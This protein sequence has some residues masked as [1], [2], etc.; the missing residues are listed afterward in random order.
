MP[1]D[2]SPAAG[3]NRRELARPVTWP[4][5]SGRRFPLA[6]KA[7]LLAPEKNSHHRPYISSRHLGPPRVNPWAAPVLPGAAPGL[8]TRCQPW[9][10]QVPG[11][12]QAAPPPVLGPSPPWSARSFVSQALLSRAPGDPITC[13]ATFP[14]HLLCA[15]AV[16]A[17]GAA[18]VNEPDLAPA[19]VHRA[20]T[21][22][23]GNKTGVN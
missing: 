16:Q 8:P 10:P 15:G 12:S 18:L 9:S 17:P 2:R 5:W 7:W 22:A 19:L 20:S 14:E 1:L 3:D 6:L 11:S 13:P 4:G 23:R 21:P